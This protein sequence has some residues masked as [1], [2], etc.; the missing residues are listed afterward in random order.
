M[1]KNIVLLLLSIILA[2]K[3]WSQQTVSGRI[4]DDQ[5]KEPL[6]GV[7]VLI[8]NTQTGT[9]TDEG[10]NFILKSNESFDSVEISYIGY[11][12]TNLKIENSQK[13]AVGLVPSS[14]NIDE[15]VIS[16]SREKQ[17][18]TDVPMAI[19]KL[20]ATTIDDAK[21]T[22]LVE[23]INKVPGVAMLNLNNE[24][25]M[26][27]IRQ[28]M[29]SNAY[30]L[31]MED[32]IPLHPMGIFNHNELIEMNIFTVNNV[33]VIKGPASS[34]Y[35]PEAV[36]GAINFIT[37]EPTAIP[38]AKVGTQFDNFGYKRV[39]YAVGG[40]LTDKI[41]MYIGGFYGKQEDGWL[42]YSD[43]DKNSINARFD[44]NLSDKTTFTLATA[45]NDYYSETSGSID[46]TDFFNRTYVN[47]NSFTYRSVNA[48]RARLGVNHSWN[49]KNNTQVNL[50][51]RENSIGQNPTYRISWKKPD[52][53]A[54]GEI[55]KIS[56]ESFGFIAQHSLKLDALK[57]KLIG[58]VSF[59]HSPNDYYSYQVDLKANLNAEGNVD[60]YTI[61]R[62]RPD[63]RTSDYNAK[64]LNSA[65][66]IQAEIKPFE[67]LTITLG[68]RYDNMGFRYNN[69]LDATSGKTSYDKFT[70]KVGA[71]YKL[72][73]N[74]GVY[75]NYSLGFSPP[76]LTTI[77]TKVPNSDP[78]QFYY[79]L[80]PA[81]FTNYEV[82]GWA[83]LIKNKLD[84]DVAFYLLK[85]E[86]ELLSVRQPDNTSLYEAAGETTHKGIEYGL[87]YHPN[88]EWT[89]RFG[90]TNAIHKFDEFIL[91][92]R[93]SDEI[94]NVNGK[95]MPSAPSWI[96]NSE[97]IYKPMFL[98]GFRVGVEWQHMSS[99]YQN[100]VNT[101]VYDE[102]GAFGL[103]GISVLSFRTGYEWSGV[104]V[105]MNVLNITDELYA[106]NATRGNTA[107]STSTYVAAPPRTFV[108][109]LQYNFSSKKII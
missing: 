8:P 98:D 81:Q 6:L 4:Y 45:Y 108:F 107:A 54:T 50:F 109:G 66:Y 23:L 58:G 96:A 82:G 78:P 49:E 91:S 74:V 86:N 26:M 27:S 84:L 20:S 63:I 25:H 56:F 80:E 83:S 46:S 21:A 53:T 24:Q 36:G 48:V 28:P 102:R 2:P 105:F 39:Q 87:N 22:L 75:G 59:D 43:Y 100:Q 65:A 38:T 57:T 34:L 85:G 9:T 44:Y 35:G 1:N 97:I 42:T 52:T 32:G 61:I 29:G 106:F 3:L 70:P 71:T 99:W 55:N 92:T 41:G 73:P 62:E 13:M 19:S 30:Y 93:P 5:T 64:L 33:E 88:T 69:I 15:V 12:S 76:S 18:R 11:L 47:N 37:K 14:I 51:Y 94:Q 77:F 95:T 89:I 67:A 103:K 68:G 79:D 60:E 17:S 101:S 40:M 72:T 10:G 31:Y 104:E 90:G 16:G 7:T